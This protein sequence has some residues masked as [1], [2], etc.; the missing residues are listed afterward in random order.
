MSG[1]ETPRAAGDCTTDNKRPALCLRQMRAVALR[2]DPDV[3]V[4][5]LS[6][7]VRGF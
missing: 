2:A 1:N 3:D 4:A 5:A 6:A 7:S